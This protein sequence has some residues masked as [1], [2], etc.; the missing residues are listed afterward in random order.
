ML[1]LFFC[2]ARSFP[3]RGCG[4][5]PMQASGPRPMR[6]PLLIGDGAGA[7]ARWVFGA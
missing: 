6:R 2:V 3:R 7:L 1:A 4:F 5:H